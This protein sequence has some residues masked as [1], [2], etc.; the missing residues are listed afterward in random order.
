MNRWV[1]YGPCALSTVSVFSCGTSGI[2]TEKRPSSELNGTQPLLSAVLLGAGVVL[3]VLGGR[4]VCSW[5]L[6]GK[7]IPTV[8][9]ANAKNLFILDIPSGQDSEPP[10]YNRRLPRMTQILRPCKL[11]RHVKSR[12]DRWPSKCGEVY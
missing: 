2:M 6:S 11:S 12:R 7:L 10:D 1:V 5:A 8:I 4:L 3:G 9:M